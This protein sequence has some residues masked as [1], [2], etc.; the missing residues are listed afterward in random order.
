MAAIEAKSVDIDARLRKLL[1][2]YQNTVTDNKDRELFEALK[3][4]RNKASDSLQELLVNSRT[5]KNKEALHLFET[6]MKPS[7]QTFSEAIQA[8]MVWNKAGV[9]SASKSI[10]SLVTF[11]GSGLMIGFVLAVT[12]AALRAF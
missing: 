8:E 9:E 3:L 11:A 4:S 1:S 5:N 10:N 6:R 7:F 12:G 2:G